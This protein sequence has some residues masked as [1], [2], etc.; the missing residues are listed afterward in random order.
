MI[1]LC[2][3]AFIRHW[4]LWPSPSSLGWPAAYAPTVKVPTWASPIGSKLRIVKRGLFVHLEELRKE[5]WSV[6]FDVPSLSLKAAE[7]HQERVE[8][9]TVLCD[10]RR[11]LLDESLTSEERRDEFQKQFLQAFPECS[12][13]VKEEW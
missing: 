10:M 2:A 4:R 8:L 3:S 9:R 12:E 5:G 1:A 11:V 13:M 7:L 6:S